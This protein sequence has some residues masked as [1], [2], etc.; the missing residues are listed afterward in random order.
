M[1]AAAP[2][3]RGAGEQRP[4]WARASC[5]LQRFRVFF[6]IRDGI[7]ILGT[8]GRRARP[9][10]VPQPTHRLWPGLD[11]QRWGE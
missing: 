5:D 11:S 7:S 2:R 8:A 3:S 6:F 10:G 4:P 1:P 9:A